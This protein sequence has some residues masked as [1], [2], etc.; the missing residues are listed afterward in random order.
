METVIKED[1]EAADS[2]IYRGIKVAMLINAPFFASLLLDMMTVRIGKFPYIFGKKTPTGATDGVTIWLDRDFL[3]SLRIEERVFLVCHELCH[4]MWNHMPRSRVYQELGFD[5]ERFKPKLWNKAGDYVINAMLVECSL[6]QM[7]KMGLLDLKRFSGDIAVD[8]A[9]RILNKSHPPQKPKSGGGMGE[10]GNG[11]DDG[12]GDGDG[13]DENSDECMDVHVTTTASTENIEHEWTRAIESAY[14]QAKSVGKMPGNLERLVQKLLEPQ[15]LWQNHLQLEVTRTMQRTATTWTRPHRRRL[16]SQGIYL[17]A[18]TGHGAGN[19]VVAVDT[20]GSIGP[21]ELSIFLSEAEGILSTC[22]P[23]RVFL[24]GCDETVNT[25]VELAYGDTLQ[26]NIPIM[27]GGGGTLFDP[28]FKWV[29]ENGVRP[30][31][32]IYLTDMY[33]ERFPEEQPPY[34]VIWCSSTPGKVGPF[35]RTVYVDFKERS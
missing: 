35:G 1:A 7:P 14:V 26:G 19:V 12:D 30:S 9:Y 11:G 16:V 27:G 2:A 20:S 4:A 5:G 21:P 17:P 8:E 18:Y 25:V 6:G 32:L 15:I 13:D 34:P 24:I 23:D 10:P 29:A 31:A 28:V 3:A 33:P 22:H